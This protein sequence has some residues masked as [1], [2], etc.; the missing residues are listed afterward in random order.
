MTPRVSVIMPIYNGQH[1]V[2][3]AINSVLMQSFSDFEL[4]LV[5]DSSTDKSL[6]ICRSIQDHRIRIVNHT[7]NKGIAAAR[8]TGIRH[9]IG[10]YIALLNSADMWHPDKLKMHVKH[11]SQSPKV[12][13][14]FSRSSF[15]SHKGRLIHFYQM[16]QLTGITAAHLL[17]RNPVGNGSAAVIRRETLNDIRFQALNHSENY[18]C[19]FDERFRQSEDI[20]CWLRI[21]ATTHWKM[22]GIPAPLTFYRLSQQGVSSNIIKKLACWEMMI[23]KAR[24]FAP[25][26]LKRHEQD[27]RAYQ[28]RYLARQAIRNGQ[29]RSAIQLINQALYVSPNIMMTETGRTFIT[30]TAAYLLWVLPASLYKVFENIGQFLM[31]HIQAKRI[32]KDGVKSSLIS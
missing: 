20:E 16:P 21:V 30:L 17:C 22:E 15:M 4:I 26:L 2:K 27:A 31:G 23:D 28:L 25:K 8:N 12:G 14:S 7:Q 10:R 19:Y 32:S 18:T 6:A 29:G 1:F 5:N 9:A 3:S 13:I 11:L 24:L